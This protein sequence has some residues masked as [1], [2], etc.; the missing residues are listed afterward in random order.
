MEP[1]ETLTGHTFA[2]PALLA[3]AL[4]HPSLAYETQKDHPNN[5]RLEY[6]GDAVLQLIFTD[7]LFV[8]FPHFSEGGLTKLRSRL[9]SRPALAA[10]ARRIALGTYLRMGRGE[11]VSG[12]RDRA[13]TL[14]DA[15]EALVAA[16]Y[17]DAGLEAARS[18]VLRLCAEDIAH[19]NDAPVELN[20]KGELQEFLQAFA[21]GSP[22]YSITR[23]DGPDHLKVFDA[24]VDW[25]GKTLGIGTGASKKEAETAAAAS[26]LGGTVVA[27]L[28][29]AAKAGA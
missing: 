21:L 2:N 3:E 1:L 11:D 8:A 17:L 26:A 29:G 5:Q 12:G 10:Y 19:I 22:R 25:N 14:A 9:V 16:I 24:R 28:R 15:F 13:S 23:E 27:E 7:H 6:L 4:T 18:A 20:P